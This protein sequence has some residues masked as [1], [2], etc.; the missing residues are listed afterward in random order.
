[1]LPSTGH[2]DLTNGNVFPSGLQIT[3]VGDGVIEGVNVDVKVSVRVL[4]QVGVNVK[5]GV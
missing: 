1:M 3:K 2:M 5:V 4:V